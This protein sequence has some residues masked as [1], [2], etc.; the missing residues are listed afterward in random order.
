VLDDDVG[1]MCRDMNS[2]GALFYQEIA[3]KPW[4]LR[5]YFVLTPEGHRIGF[6]EEIEQD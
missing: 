6:A 4:G 1:A 3:D 2:R 5:E